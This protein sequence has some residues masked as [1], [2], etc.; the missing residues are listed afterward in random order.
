MN[1][2]GKVAIVTG[3]ASGIGAATAREFAAGGA[4]AIIFDINQAGGEQMVAQMRADGGKADY[5]RVDVSDADACRAAVQR[6]AAALGRVDYLVNCAAS[7]ISKGLDVTT[8]DWERSL[9]VNVRGYA[10]MVQACFEPMKA[11]GSGAIV[12]IASISAHIAQPDRWTYNA[13][14]G[15]ILTMSKCQALD[16]APYGIR[17]NV[18]SPGWIWTP[19]VAK[20][21]N[22]DRARWEPVWGRYHMLRRLGEPR[23]VARAALFLCSDDASFIT[24]AELP[25]D[26]GYLGLGSEGLGDTSSFAGTA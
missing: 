24:G 18:V 4:M 21:A 8:A 5:Q 15:A 16:L 22:G 26:G 2:T 1:W 17:V 25:V 10:N 7:F 13:C 12:N 9:G 6:V 11:T 3:G 20:A 23:E 19:E 14:K